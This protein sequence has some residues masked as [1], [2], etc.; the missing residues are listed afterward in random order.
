MIQSIMQQDKAPSNKRH[1]AQNQAD[2][3]E[4]LAWGAKELG[5]GPEG[6]DIACLI[7]RMLQKQVK[8][9]AAEMCVSLE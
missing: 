3:L 2:N 1:D 6:P 9:L 8:D 4:T 5:V 7:R